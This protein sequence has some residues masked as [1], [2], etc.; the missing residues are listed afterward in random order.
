MANE[1][2]LLQLTQLADNYSLRQKRAGAVQSSF[3]LVNDAHNKALKALRDYAEH[4]TTVDVAG[5]QAA[6]GRV[7][8]REEAIDPL[9]PDLRREI[10]TLAALI[11]ALK[12]SAAALRSEPVDVV[13]LD[14][15]LA[16]LQ[17]SK[18][19][20][21]LDAVPELQNELE[22]AQRALGDEFGQKLRA[23]LAAQGVTIGGRPPKFEIGRFELDVNFA[24]R[25]GMLR[26]G[27]DVV[28][29]HIPVT[30]DATVKAYQA[31]VKAIAGRKEDGAAWLAQLHEAYQ[32]ARRKRNVNGDRINIVDVYL[33]MVLLR[34]GRAFASE[35]SKRTFTDYSRPQ[36][37]YDFAEFAGR[38]RLAYQG[39]VV[40][41][42]SAT[43][44]Q[45]DSAAKSMWM[46][47]GDSPYDGNFVGDIQ[48]VKE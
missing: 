4:D 8:V 46:V 15:A 36:F 1:S 35:P 14:K 42:H 37:L 24:R 29:P 45:T 16:V 28:A 30:V 38:Q 11:T 26:Y 17:E 32:V 13:R 39:Y 21:V 27:K 48:F 47:E 19:Q 10:K 25:Y 18:E 23:A 3:K 9:A 31:A 6:F 43:K 5:A 41:K 44:S 33:E 7:H 34:Q 20:P 2:L 40:Q 22:L 12:D